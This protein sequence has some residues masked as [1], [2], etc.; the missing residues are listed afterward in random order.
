[1]NNSKRTCII[2]QGIALYAAFQDQPVIAVTAE[3]RE[4]CQHW[5][6][7]QRMYPMFASFV[8]NEHFH[9]FD[10]VNAAF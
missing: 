6:A 3:E 2:A 9:L 1:M 10:R 7:W 8:R 5:E 4:V